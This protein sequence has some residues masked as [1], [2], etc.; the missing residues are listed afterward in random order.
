MNRRN[1]LKFTGVGFI[2]APWLISNIALL[3]PKI[4]IAAIHI[5]PVPFKKKKFNPNRPF[6]KGIKTKNPSYPD[7]VKLP[8]LSY[9][10]L[11]L[12]YMTLEDAKAEAI[13][14]LR[15]WLKN[16]IHVEIPIKYHK[17]FRFR[18]EIDSGD[19]SLISVATRD[20]KR[21]T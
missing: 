19:G 7:D 14:A 5:Q 8:Y 4:A 18:F 2:S 9:R 21:L 1:F 11:D 6:Y 10:R 16:N 17:Q 12:G 20:P 3:K 15:S 13:K